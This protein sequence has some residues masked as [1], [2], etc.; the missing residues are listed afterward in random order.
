MKDIRI[1]A[2]HCEN[3]KGLP[4]IAVT[5]GD[6][7]V[8]DICGA[9]ATGKTSINDL[10][11]WV[12]FGKDSK[13]VEKFEV[14]RLLPDGEKEHQTVI[15]GDVELIVDGTL[16]TFQKDQKEI[17]QTKRGFTEQLFKGNQ[18]QYMI[19]GYPVSEAEYKAKIREIVDEDIFRM[20]TSP[21]YFI[22]L[23][24]KDQ[25]QVLMGLASEK[26]DTELA[27]EMGGFE[28]IIDD[29]T[30]APDT[31]SV[32]AKYRKAMADLN[33]KQKEL[34]VRI[35]E[36]L[37][38]IEEMDF[39]AI[40]ARYDAV[41]AE[42]DEIDQ[43]LHSNA[44]DAKKAALK[45]EITMIDRML[46]AMKET[47]NLDADS[48]RNELTRKIAELHDEFQTEMAT[49]Q[50]KVRS[51]RTERNDIET[52]MTSA[53]SDIAT[54]TEAKDYWNRKWLEC[55]ND[56]Y[57]EG[58]TTCPTCGQPLPES[59][60]EKRKEA[61]EK[62][63][64]RQYD[65]IMEK[66][67]NAVQRFDKAQEALAGYIAEF[68]RLSQEITA[69]EKEAE[70]LT[71]KHHEA[72]LDL[73]GQ[74]ADIKKV[75]PMTDAEYVKLTEKRKAKMDEYNAVDTEDQKKELLHAQA[76]LRDEKYALAA[77][78]SKKD[79]NAKAQ[80]RAEELRAELRDVSEKALQMEGK[81]ELLDR[82]VREK[83]DYISNS[84]NS[85]FD[86][87]TWKL[88]DTQINGGIRPTC[89]LTVNGVPFSGLNNGMRIVAGLKVI[90]TMQE[91]N[92]VRSFIFID[93]AEAVNDVNYPAMDNQMIFLK[94]TNNP[95]LEFINR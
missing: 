55:K 19:N 7:T 9:N 92:G 10:V 17:W 66:G 47:L 67:N 51:I 28:S 72:V 88:F 16:I 1:K 35:D 52:E 87:I 69:A 8:T 80:S 64:K 13:G 83:L 29:L 53:R 3:F 41:K 79:S 62:E 25:R 21:L 44:A 20:I 89:E 94:V 42:M 57:K 33:A 54:Y 82:F 76:T 58:D 78:L 81:I 23:P 84:I 37:H 95:E 93:N 24:W 31:D 90:K 59:M 75:D 14:R 12:L 5:F 63:H 27:I 71:A 46:L 86:G 36:A 2:I 56:T 15:S 38:A 77:K 34:P 48:K 61:W 30:Q 4:P 26:S 85:K 68:E 11:T 6:M 73:E 50:R 22:T 74:L 43:K 40:Q 49:R 32:Q 39:D 91:I 65:E 60:L 18:N 70:E 45:E